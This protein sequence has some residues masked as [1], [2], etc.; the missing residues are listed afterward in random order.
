MTQTETDPQLYFADDGN[1]RSARFDDI[2]YSL[3][4]GL[5]ESRAVFLNGCAMPEVWAGR[6]HFT[7][8][9]LG[10]GTGLNIAALMQLW[11]AQRPESGHLHIFSVEGFLM[12]RDAAASAL[13][14]WPDMAPFAAELLA[15]WPPQR[16]G[17]HIMRFPQ[18]GVTLILALMDV[19]SA[20]SQWQGKADAWFLDGFSPACN[21]DMWADDVL[22]AVA[23]KTAPGARLA[24]FTVAGF[25]RR[26]L[27]AAGFAVSKQPGFG[28]KR[29]RLEAI[30]PGEPDLRHEP[31]RIAVVGGGIAGASVVAA[32]RDYGYAADLIDPAPGSGASGNPAGLLTPR[33]DAGGGAIS[34]LFA[35]AFYYATGLLRRDVPDAILSEGVLQRPASDRDPARFAKIAG[36]VAFDALDMGVEAAGLRLPR[37]LALD[38]RTVVESLLG[39]INR[40]T[41]T[42][43]ST[44][45]YDIIFM[46][47]GE[48]IFDLDLSHSLDL[49]PVRGQIEVAGS[50]TRDPQAQ[51]W[52][53]YYVPTPDGFVFGATHVR[54]DRGTEVCEADRAHN[55]DTLRAV[56]A[57]EAAAAE[58]GTHARAAIRVTTRDHLPVM[59]PVSPHT[60]ALTGLG[61]RGFCLAPLLGRALVAQA[62]GLP[63]PLPKASAH[64]VRPDRFHGG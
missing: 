14:A 32:L 43:D 11:A 4:D 12:P 28:K 24:T 19:R 29:E 7:V 8:A 27:Q 52:G 33:L 31:Q 42:A 17:F 25:V 34:D 2:Y 40:V 20:L 6:R 51:A 5:S 56:L 39:D 61:A 36:Q 45:G 21:P 16:R 62:L 44:E 64:L 50:K 41:K 9:E 59:G 49:R 57:D 30:F 54:G 55:L 46:T 37:A 58:A 22:Q 15:Q 23:D 47:C 10:F 13:S 53:G 1:P 38:P 18:W 35:D 48:G 63:S 60:Y 26:G 3:Q